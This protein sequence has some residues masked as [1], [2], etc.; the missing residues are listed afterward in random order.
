[1]AVA[2]WFVAHEGLDTTE[3][4]AVTVGGLDGVVLDLRL[5]EG[6]ASGC[7]YE[8]YEGI[9]MVPMLIGVAP[10]DVHHVVLGPSTTR[11]YLLTGQN[12]RVVAIEVTDVPG[13]VE[14]DE[15]DAIVADFDF[16]SGG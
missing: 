9:P 1:M 5:A 13:G 16:E 3:P 6:Y 11:L 12:G 10:S 2:S 7:P 4:V 14:L 15:L 8:G